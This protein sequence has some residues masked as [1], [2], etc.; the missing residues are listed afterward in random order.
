MP[1]ILLIIYFTLLYI[2]LAN[3]NWGYE[4]EDGFH[5]GKP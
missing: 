4:D 3:T 2:T 5:E 1:F